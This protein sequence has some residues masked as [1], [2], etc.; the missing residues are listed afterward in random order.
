M[1]TLLRVLDFSGKPLIYDAKPDETALQVSKRLPD[2]FN[3]LWCDRKIMEPNALL[4][5]CGAHDILASIANLDLRT[6]VTK[7]HLGEAKWA[8]ANGCPWD[9]FTCVLAALNGHLEVLKWAAVHGMYGPV[10][11]LPSTATSRS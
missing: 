1:T 9:A 8:R 6:A 2:S 10:L 11:G 7:N 5:T 4:S 3:M